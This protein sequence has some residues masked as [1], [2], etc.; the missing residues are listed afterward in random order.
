MLYISNFRN[1][2]DDPLG[3]YYPSNDKKWP[4]EI[5]KYDGPEMSPSIKEGRKCKY[6][7]CKA[8][9]LPHESDG[10]CCNNGQVIETRL[11]FK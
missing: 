2:G 10:T 6:N 11:L 1:S 5:R 4:D 3:L 8:R 7:D 9:L